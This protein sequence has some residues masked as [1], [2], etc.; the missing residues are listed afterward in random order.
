MDFLLKY[1]TMSGL[2]QTF[3]MMLACTIYC[4]YLVSDSSKHNHQPT[5]DETGTVYTILVI[6]AVIHLPQFIAVNLQ[7]FISS[8]YRQRN[9]KELEKV[10]VVFIVVLPLL[11]AFAQI[12]W[13]IAESE[14]HYDMIYFKWIIADVFLNGVGS[15]NYLLQLER[16]AFE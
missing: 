13:L 16:I 11:L 7:F 15:T 9:E 4:I 10:Q 3:Y 1:K 14:K 6:G 12:I 2:Y 8:N 5:S